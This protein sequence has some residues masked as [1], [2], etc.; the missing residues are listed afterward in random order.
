MWICHAEWPLT[1]IE[2]CHALGIELGSTYFN[3]GNIPSIATLVGCCQGLITVDKEA[4]TVRLVHFTL[5]EYLSA[6][7]GIFNTP[8]SAIAEI[9]LTYLNC[10]QVNAL[11]ASSFD[12][13]SALIHDKPFLEYCS[14]YWGVHVKKEHSERAES[15]ALQLLR[16]YD[17]H[18]SAIM[19]IK[20]SLYSHLD[21]SDNLL[22]SGLHCA[23]YFGIT[24]VVATLIEMGGYDLNQG[25][26][27][28]RTAL[29][30]GC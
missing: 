17:G 26:C 5:R 25:D 16:D 20:E 9:Y 4:L 2:L 18:I 12:H 13:L 22:S 27:W 30:F 21:R 29:Y 23:S 19:L 28:E 8:H 1:P 7:P 6:H 11:S 3:A 10:H 15:L 14:L 24:G